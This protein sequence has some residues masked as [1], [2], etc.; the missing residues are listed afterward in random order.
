MSSMISESRSMLWAFVSAQQVALGPE[1]G[2][3]NNS[4]IHITA[5][6]VQRSILLVSIYC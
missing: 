6:K 4:C 5:R 2:R 1:D 3:T